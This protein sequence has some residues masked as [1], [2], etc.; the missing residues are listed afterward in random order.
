MVTIYDSITNSYIMFVS[1]GYD[2]WGFACNFNPPTSG[3]NNFNNSNEFSITAS[4]FVYGMTVYTS[5]YSNTSTNKKFVIAA[6]SN[7]Y[8]GYFYN[9]V[10]NQNNLITTANGGTLSRN[11]TWLNTGATLSTT[12]NLTLYNNRLFYSLP[13]GNIGSALITDGTIP[14]IGTNNVTYITTTLLTSSATLYPIGLTI[15]TN[16]YLYAALGNTTSAATTGVIKVI[17][18]TSTPSLA[19]TISL[20][21]A[22]ITS[23]G[24]PY[25]LIWESYNLYIGTTVGNAFTSTTGNIVYCNTSSVN[26]TIVTSTLAAYKT[27]TKCI[28]AMAITGSYLYTS[29]LNSVKTTISQYQFINIGNNPTRIKYNSGSSYI[30]ICNNFSSINLVTTPIYN[31]SAFSSGFYCYYNG[32]KYDMAKLYKIN[33]TFITNP[34]YPINIYSIYNNISYDLAGIFNPDT[35]NGSFIVGPGLTLSN[36]N[37]K[38]HYLFYATSINGTTMINP[39]STTVTVTKTIVAYILMIGGGGYGGNT[40]YSQ[41]GNGGGQGGNAAYAR[42]QL[43][44]AT[45]TI[46]IDSGTPANA[47]YGQGGSTVTFSGNGITFQATGG[48]GGQNGHIPGYTANPSN[49][50]T[51]P[52]TVLNSAATF[53]YARG[54]NGTSKSSI[55]QNGY[56]IVPS[57][58]GTGAY[59]YYSGKALGQTT[60]SVTYTNYYGITYQGVQDNYYYVPINIQMFND[61]SANTHAYNK[62]HQI[63]FGAGGTDNENNPGYSSTD[64]FVYCGNQSGAPYSINAFQASGVDNYSIGC[65]GWGAPAS[66]T[67]CGPGGPAAFYLYF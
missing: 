26:E 55:G 40:P 18:I 41:L 2:Y 7:G 38:G 67:P 36:I 63:G 45:Y 51:S 13:N 14:T 9:F 39:L 60:S 34:L 10:M 42:I 27:S 57:N 3:T 8:I 46:T 17:N 20:S 15:D 21:A 61:M 11:S 23:W 53:E 50:L 12:T 64:G 30:D 58:A 48:S 5:A 43:T 25:A 59:T 28:G 66:A 62:F 31:G 56:V 65:G 19:Y 29:S 1:S 52:T 33:N 16:G 37:T 44:P 49:G 32:T 4:P 47:T 35:T 22:N 6:L 54:S 24:N